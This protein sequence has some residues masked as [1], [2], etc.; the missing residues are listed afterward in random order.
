[1]E[2]LL[3]DLRLQRRGNILL[4]LILMSCCICA[5]YLLYVMDIDQEGLNT[6]IIIIGLIICGIVES[7]GLFKKEY[8][9]SC[10]I[11]GKEIFIKNQKE[12]VCIKFDE[13]K[14]IYYKEMRYGGKWLEPIGYRMVIETKMKKYYWD[15]IYREEEKWE[16]TGLFCLYQYLLDNKCVCK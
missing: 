8:K 11:Q 2:V 4:F 16:N 6:T 9:T 3:G 1:M 10:E 7:S 5:I 13:I 12:E 14:R 15:S